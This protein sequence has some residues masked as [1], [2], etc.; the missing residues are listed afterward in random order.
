VATYHSV[1]LTHWYPNQQNPINGVF[2]REHALATALF[3]QV[4]VIT[5]EG[6]GP[7]SAAPLQ[8]RRETDEAL[9]VYRLRYRR[10]RLPKS[11][12]LRRWLGVKQILSDL[13]QSNHPPDI[14]HAHVYS[15]ADLAAI[16]G[17]IYHIPAVMTE[18]ASSYPRQLF[19]PWQRFKLRLFVNQM[20]CILPVSQDLAQHIQSY[21]IRRPFH[22]IPNAVNPAIFHP[23]AM[24]RTAAQRLI[25]H[26]GSLIPVKAQDILLQALH[27]LR[28]R[29]QDFRCVLLGEGPQRPQL[30]ALVETLGL[31]DCVELPGFVQHTAI[32]D[33][34]RQADLFVLS[35]RWENQPVVVL[36]ALMCGLPVVAPRVGGLPEMITPSNG[37][38]FEAGDPAALAD[39]LD[40][41]LENLSLF[42]PQVLHTHAARCYS[43]ASVGQQIHAI[44]QQLIGNADE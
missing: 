29:R 2:V 10:A 8:I 40:Q 4:S 38:L 20:Q 26:V 35:S 34:M 11:T 21:G 12:W 1:F 6:I 17:R 16:F 39:S 28:K 24:K 32:A 25:L 5:I 9:T 27:L 15:S 3:D 33:W 43:Y 44:Y 18:H 30:E 42:S 7:N 19:T 22:I 36:E 31:K 13:A 41:I 14:L 37:R 23:P